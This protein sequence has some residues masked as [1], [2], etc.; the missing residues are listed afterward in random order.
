MERRDAG[1]YG[2]ITMTQAVIVLWT[3]VGVLAVSAAWVALA[4]NRLVL[5]R[6]RYANALSQ[7]DVQLKRRH[8]LVPNLV[9]TA[10]GYL[11][12]ERE[13]L[14]AVTKARAA[15]VSSWNAAHG[16]QAGQGGAVGGADGVGAGAGVG[17][18]V[19]T[20]AAASVASVAVAEGQ[21]GS[22]LGAFLGRVEAYPQLKAD[23]IMRR[24]MEELTTTENRIGFAR[25]AYNDA[26]MRYSTARQT[27]PNV[28]IAGPL[29]FGEVPLWQ[30]ETAAQREPVAV[31]L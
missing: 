30:I 21:L 9:E 1:G 23:T 6:N 4:Y 16:V 10:K 25:Q 27:F 14:E 28:L 12:H 18:V 7:I 11:S 15:A 19:G 3:G 2:A 31:K 13:T 24:L 26:V 5:L 22:A 20:M 29:G 17:A 8:D